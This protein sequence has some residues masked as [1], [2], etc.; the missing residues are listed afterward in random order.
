MHSR[1]STAVIAAGSERQ[2]KLSRRAIW[3]VAIQNVTLTLVLFV[4]CIAGFNIF[5]QARIYEKIDGK[6]ESE[7]TGF[8]TAQEDPDARGIRLPLGLLPIVYFWDD[9][10]G[11]V[12]PF[13]AS[14]AVPEDYEPLLAQEPPKGFS[15][16]SVNGRSYRV[17]RVDYQDPLVFRYSHGDFT[18]SRTVSFKDVSNEVEI[19]QTLETGS[20]IICLFGGIIY[21][22]I[23][24][25]FARRSIAPIERAWQTQRTFL[26]DTSH[27]LRNPLAGIK[28]NAELLLQT[29]DKTVLESIDG[30]SGI[31]RNANRMSDMLSTLLTLAR[32]DED[33]DEIAHD[34]IDLS[35][36]LRS[37]CDQ[38]SQIAYARQIGLIG[39]IEGGLTI[40]GD[41]ARLLEF[42]D[43]LLDNAVRYSMPERTVTV[44]AH[45]EH[46]HAIVTIQDQGIGISKEELSTVFERFHRT[47]RSR[48]MYPDGTGLGLPVAQWIARQHGAEFEIESKENEGTLV[49]VRFRIE[50]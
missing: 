17:Y 3:R 10:T 13:P 29:P 36:L 33:S 18:V 21:G 14:E 43:V 8:V 16:Q 11:Y 35:A 30:V 2:S 6:M 34:R 20:V 47:Q 26:A 22:T 37:I 42:F 49:T 45:R 27:E 1:A 44:T 7:R 46:R 24:L 15:T 40:P 39:K 50:D 38:F 28:A 32:S 23:S 25:A 5:L 41:E 31:L 4:V 12:N 9:S 48:E 19:F